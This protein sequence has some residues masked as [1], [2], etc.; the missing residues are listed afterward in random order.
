[1]K[2]LFFGT[3]LA[4]SALFVHPCI[5]A[6]SKQLSE[7]KPEELKDVYFICKTNKSPLSYQPGEE[8][9]YT[10]TLHTGNDKPGNWTFSYIRQGDDNKK[11]SGSAPA[12]KPL[13]I[14]TSLDKPG[15]VSINVHLRDAKN[16]AVYYQYVHANGRTY[17]RNVSAFCGTA[18]QP[19]KLTDCGEPADFDEFWAKQ[20]K[21]L[22]EVPFAGK[23]QKKLVRETKNGY[24]YSLSIPCVA[25]RPATGYM[26]IPKNAKPKSLP[27]QFI[28]FGYSASRQG[29]P[30]PVNGRIAFYINAHGQELGREPEYY[31]K[32]FQSLRTEKYSYAFNPE[33][34]KNPET[35]FFNGMALRNL[36]AMEYAKTLPEWNGKDLTVQGGSQGGL[37]TMWA[38]ALDPD[39][40]VAK[41]SITWCCDLAGTEKKQRLSGGWR[42]K[43][44]SGLDYYDPVFMAKRVKKAEVIITR[45]GLGDYVCPPSGLAISYLNLATPNKTI[46]WY[47]N[48]SHGY[49]QP[50]P[51]IITWTTKKK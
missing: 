28:F 45:A 37:Q 48:S 13:V 16:K 42:I 7:L 34:N 21:R 38:V 49:V 8:M 14:K 4:L 24:V 3:V 12:D 23:V 15:F 43:Y 9:V 6:E 26:T 51:E 25:P 5:A 2:T 19:E 47:Q 46:H 10:I 17:K 31:T 33:E 32:F 36:R 1:M 35:A 50:N 27:L 11:F 44:V 40:T 39:V 20:K 41:P 18:V 29:I 30:N 22:A